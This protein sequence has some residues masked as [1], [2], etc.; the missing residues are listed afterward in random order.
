[1]YIYIH[2]YIYINQK[3]HTHTHT[4]IYI[5]IKTAKCI[6][7]S[8]LSF[9]LSLS[10]YIYKVTNFQDMIKQSDDEAPSMLGFS[11]PSLPIQVWPWLEAPKTND[12]CLIELLCTHSN[13]SLSSSSCR[14]ISTDIPEPF[15]PPFS[16]VH[17]FREVFRDTSRVDIELLHVSSCWSSRLCSSIW[18]FHRSSVPLV[19]FV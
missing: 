5:C 13:T 4:H 15:S 12:W 6:F 8:V 19:W 10:L 1:M 11:F 9:P 18:G 17:R 7:F 3:S 2:T 16:I 14:T